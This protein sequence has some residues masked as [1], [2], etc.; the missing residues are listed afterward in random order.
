MALNLNEALIA[1]NVGKDPEIRSM[2]SGEK[3]ASLSI[4]TNKR[5]KDKHSGEQKEQTEW[6]RVVVFGALVGVIEDYVHKG[7]NI[8]IRG[9]LRTRKWTDK[10][11]ND[12]YTTEIVVAGAQHMLRLND[13]PRKNGADRRG[14]EESGDPVDDE[15]RKP[16]KRVTEDNFDDDIPF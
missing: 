13:A 14:S 1:G 5:W 4:A 12:R 8:L 7:S 10:D 11:G 3:V 16:T 9:E 6:H 2:Q 15:R